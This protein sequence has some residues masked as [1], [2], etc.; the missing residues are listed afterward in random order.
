M[1]RGVKFVSIPV[2]DQDVAL[3]FWTE[4]VGLKVGTDQPFTPTQRWIE[5]II[6]GGGDGAGAVY[7]GRA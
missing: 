2:K 3:K 7:A 6:P 4:S 5:L 1:I